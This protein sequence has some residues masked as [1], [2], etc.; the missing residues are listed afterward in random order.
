MD[1]H[2]RF[3][4]FFRYMNGREDFWID[5]ID[6]SVSHSCHVMFHCLITAGLEP[7]LVPGKYV[8]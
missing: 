7:R 4:G 8:P 3:G 6:T 1:F 5:A 2:G